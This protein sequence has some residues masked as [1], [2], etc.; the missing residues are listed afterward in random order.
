V[1]TDRQR[2]NRKCLD[3]PRALG[4]MTKTAKNL[5]LSINV[6]L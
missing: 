2:M 6:L 1:K 4:G 3:F 5:P